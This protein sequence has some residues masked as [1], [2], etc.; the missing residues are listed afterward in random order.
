MMSS[1]TPGFRTR[2]WVWEADQCMEWDSGLEETAKYKLT[3][4]LSSQLLL[5][6]L[7]SLRILWTSQE[8]IYKVVSR[9]NYSFSIGWGTT[10]IFTGS[11]D[12][13]IDDDIHLT[14][15]A[16]ALNGTSWANLN[17]HRWEK[18]MFIKE[19]KLGFLHYKYNRLASHLLKADEVNSFQMLQ[20]GSQACQ[21]QQ[22]S[23]SLVSMQR[24]HG[25]RFQN[26]MGSR[27]LHSH[28]TTFSVSFCIF[29]A[30]PSS[31]CVGCY[32]SLL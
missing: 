1:K 19:A 32:H 27:L 26:Q 23:S 22:F 24:R 14:Q 3:E 16:V 7:L 25:L 4:V 6:D 13:M 20:T 5:L 18:L 10:C 28:H 8:T 31:K 12:K 9:S 30:G 21:A 11:K 29:L 17:S 2:W 15:F